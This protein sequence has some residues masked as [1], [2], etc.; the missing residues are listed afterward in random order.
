MVTKPWGLRARLALALL[1][2]G[3]S[4]FHAGPTRAAAEDGGLWATLGIKGPA[5]E[6]L[7]SDLITQLRYTEDIS[8]LERIVVRP[9]LGLRF[10]TMFSGA[11]GYDAHIIRFPTAKLEQRVW[12]QLA[13]NHGVS[14]TTLQYRFR[15]EERFIENVSGIALTGRFLLQATAP[16]SVADLNLVGSNELFLNFNSLDNGP[17][18]GFDQNRLY[19]GF[20]R[21]LAT[22]L[23]IA[24]G[25]QNQYINKTG[26]D[27]MNHILMVG[28][29]TQ[30]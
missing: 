17:Q 27:P 19:I 28:L 11:I 22:R 26:E 6:R 13:F 7:F 25:Y 18:Q 24:L 2:L 5:T 10:T 29:N 3:V 12:Q 8:R 14:D 20:S 4:L 15:L 30:F 23:G 1:T 16:I 21:K 9:S